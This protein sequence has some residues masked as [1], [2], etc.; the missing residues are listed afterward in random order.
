[1]AWHPTSDASLDYVSITGSSLMDDQV[2]AVQT[3]TALGAPGRSIGS[4]GE[5]FL[6]CWVVP[7]LGRLRH[8]RKDRPCRSL[9]I[10]A[11]SRRGY[12][13]VGSKLSTKD[14]AKMATSKAAM[15]Q[16]IIDGR[17]DSTSDCQL[18]LQIWLP[19]MSTSSSR[20]AALLWRSRRK[21]LRRVRRS[22]LRWA[23]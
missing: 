23:V 6:R 3:W 17:K 20:L 14:S 8:M 7:Q 1:M 5:T 22:S 18:W 13:P 16:S 4:S 19:G 21:F 12:S 11:R 10:F 9:A 15:S 2:M